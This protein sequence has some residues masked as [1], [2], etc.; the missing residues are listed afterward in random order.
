MPSYTSW[1]RLHQPNIPQH[2]PSHT[3][4]SHHPANRPRCPAPLQYSPRY[5]R[6]LTNPHPRFR[7]P[8]AHRLPHHAPGEREPRPQHRQWRSLLPS[9]EERFLDAQRSPTRYAQAASRSVSSRR[10]G[11]RASPVSTAPSTFIRGPSGRLVA[12][13]PGGHRRVLSEV[14]G[15]GRAYW[16]CSAESCTHRNWTIPGSLC[17][18]PGC[19]SRRSR[20]Q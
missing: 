9:P 16:L 20:G 4:T 3:Y 15:G 17:G 2:H 19:P 14:R 6:H 5:P 1:T 11:R 8:A 13:Q 12:P 7:L 10:V 18:R